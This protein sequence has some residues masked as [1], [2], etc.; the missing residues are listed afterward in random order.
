MPQLDG[1][2]AS[3]RT[4][5]LRHSCIAVVPLAC[6]PP[7]ISMFEVLK[8]SSFSPGTNASIGCSEL[9]LSI[10]TPLAVT[11]RFVSNTIVS[12]SVVLMAPIAM[13]ANCLV[14]YGELVTLPEIVVGQTYMCRH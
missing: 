4:R 12:L 11:S 7:S 5:L 8:I 6:T 3:V 10:P 9:L 2:N 1:G 13:F 14:G